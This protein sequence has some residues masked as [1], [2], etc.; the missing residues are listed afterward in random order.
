MQLASII[1]RAPGIHQTRAT[2]RVPGT[3]VPLATKRAQC[4]QQALGIQRAPDI[5][6]G[7]ATQQALDISQAVGILQLKAPKR[8]HLEHIRGMATTPPPFRRRMTLAPAA[9]KKG[10]LVMTTFR[11]FVVT[12]LKVD[13]RG[14][15]LVSVPLLHAMLNN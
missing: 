3:R 10:Q 1:Q 7:L 11:L 13:S 6:R 14:L 9:L 2:N 8:N 4:I 15:I 12:K 5:P